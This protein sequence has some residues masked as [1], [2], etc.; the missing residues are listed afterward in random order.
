MHQKTLKDSI[1]TIGVYI[2]NNPSQFSIHDAIQEFNKF[3]ETFKDSNSLIPA[4]R[5]NIDLL[6]SPIRRNIDYQS[7]AR[8]A[9]QVESLPEGA[10]LLYDLN[11]E[12]NDE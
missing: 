1:Q 11:G 3:L 7:I 12:P 8:R 2:E 10:N 6:V 4:L 9:F 5:G